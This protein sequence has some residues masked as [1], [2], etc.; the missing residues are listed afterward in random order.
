MRILV[1]HWT[2][3][4]AKASKEAD[5]HSHPHFPI[6]ISNIIATMEVAM[7]TVVT[8][9]P[10]ACFP[11]IHLPFVVLQLAC[12]AL[13]FGHLHSLP[14]LSHNH[15]DKLKPGLSL[16]IY[17]YS[18]YGRRMASGSYQPVDAGRAAGVRQSGR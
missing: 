1:F 12:L 3:P 18:S 13:W 17:L 11:F 16:N 5:E 14:N 10:V 7:P 15:H 8:H 2:E 9:A 4:S 6:F